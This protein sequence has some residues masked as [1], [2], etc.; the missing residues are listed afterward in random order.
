M[1][2]A[3]AIRAALGG[4]P[5]LGALLAASVPTTMTTAPAPPWHRAGAAAPMP[6]Q[7]PALFAHAPPQDLS[8]ALRTM[9]ERVMARRLAAAAP[10]YEPIGFASYAVAP[11]APLPEAGPVP[12][13]MGPATPSAALAEVAEDEP[14]EPLA[15]G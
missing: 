14:N 1:R 2:M 3:T 9:R 4:A 6:R 8:P 12:A 13:D 11:P 15:G 5:L 10:A 7:G